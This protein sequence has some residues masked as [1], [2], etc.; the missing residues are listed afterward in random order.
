MSG[1]LNLCQVNL[2]VTMFVTQAILDA[3]WLSVLLSLQQRFELT[4]IA[5]PVHFEIDAEPAIDWTFGHVPIKVGHACLD[6][7]GE[8]LVGFLVVCQ[9]R[10]HSSPSSLLRL[11]AGWETVLKIGRQVN[12][13]VDFAAVFVL[14]R[15]SSAVGL[16][17]RV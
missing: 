17:A 3:V 7:L 11:H 16:A 2:V 4:D 15:Y 1:T 8:D 13:T 6:N 9:T 10:F 14:D 5:I 12:E